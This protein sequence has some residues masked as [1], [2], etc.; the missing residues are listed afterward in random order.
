VNGPSSLT[1]RRIAT[2]FVAF[3]LPLLSTIFVLDAFRS[4][5]DP[6][7]E[8]AAAAVAE[9]NCTRNSDPLLTPEVQ[10]QADGLHVHVLRDTDPPGSVEIRMGATR[11]NVIRVEFGRDGDAEYSD[12]LRAP[13]GEATVACLTGVGDDAETTATAE[14]RILDPLGVWRDDSL[15]CDGRPVDMADSYSFFAD[16]NPV[17]EGVARAVP[18]VLST[19]TVQLAG[20]PHEE[21]AVVIRNGRIVATMDLSTY[22]GRTFIVFLAT[23]DGVGIG[24][25]G[26]PTRG[27]LA[28]P[29]QVAGF[30]TCDQYETTCEQVYVS[31]EWLNPRADVGITRSQLIREPWMECTDDQPGGC[32]EDPRTVVV[33]V[34]MSTA[35]ASRFADEFGCGST[36]QTACVEPR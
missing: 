31:A 29:F 7:Q 36:R 2:I 19:D 12:V 28:T 27:S 17:E 30:G 11:Q 32:P 21:R 24:Q 15:D 4:D 20:F 16:Q 34:Q 9:V 18:G 33:N 3:L 8:A 25:Q 6:S 14:M 35:D 26:E 13:S 1:L 10:L 23:C 22:H 5:G